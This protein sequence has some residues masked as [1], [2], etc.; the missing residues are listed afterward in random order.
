[1]S[2][3]GWIKGG[4]KPGRVESY[5]RSISIASREGDRQSLHPIDLHEPNELLSKG[6]SEQEQEYRDHEKCTLTSTT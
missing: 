2:T 6:F 3:D 1:M 4:F 5:V